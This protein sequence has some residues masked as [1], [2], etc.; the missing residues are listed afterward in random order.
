MLAGGMVIAA[1]AMVPEAAAAGQLYV[2]AES[3]AFGNH[4][5]G[6]QI[7]E[8]IVRDPNRSDTEVAE[9]EPT[10]YVDNFKLRMAQGVDGFWYAY[11][12]SDAKIVLADADDNNLDFGIKPAD[13]KLGQS[14]LSVD[15]AGESD[16]SIYSQGI[17]LG[18]TD[19]VITNEPKLSNY[20]G[21]NNAGITPKTTNGDQ[22]SVYGQIGVNATE[23]PFIQSFDFTQGKFDIILEQAGSD[24]V[25]T[26]DFSSGGTGDYAVLKLD[27]YSGTQGSDVHM[28]ITDNALNV[29]PTNEDIVV[30]NIAI[31]GTATT[32]PLTFTNGTIPQTGG[33]SSIDA[34]AYKNGF[35][36]NGV[37]KI[38]YDANGANQALFE[39]IIT[40]DDKIADTHIVFVEN[41]DNSGI[42]TNTDNKDEANLQVTSAAKRGTTATFEYNDESY[43]YIV[44]NDF[45][46]LDM[47]ESSLGVEWNSGETLAVTLVDQD[48]NKNTK[49]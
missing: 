42:F 20:N 15:G 48:L 39:S 11:I 45:G 12:G 28:E 18:A 25:V 4:F 32:G 49:K 13:G 6:A 36:N 40:L 33:A 46:A 22:S 2:S 24:E 10:V 14:H 41:A 30:F 26:L 1:P 23:W 8:V 31:D 17:W 9:S 3:A 21:T 35:K 38:N 27:R 5:T 37:L 43:S 19:G 34:Q 47:D 44:S 29:D 16:M 7:V